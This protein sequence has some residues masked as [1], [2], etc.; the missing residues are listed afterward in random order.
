M[1]WR[2]KCAHAAAATCYACVVVSARVDDDGVAAH[3]SCKL[4][5]RCDVTLQTKKE[6]V[7]VTRLLQ[8]RLEHELFFCAWHDLTRRQLGN[9]CAQYHTTNTV[10]RAQIKATPPP[11]KQAKVQ[12]K[13]G[14]GP[15]SDARQRVGARG[16][17]RQLVGWEILG[18][19]CIGLFCWGARCV[20]R[21]ERGELTE[22]EREVGSTQASPA[23]AIG[24]I[25]Q[26]D[27]P[28]ESRAQSKVKCRA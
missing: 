24:S 12:R 17:A 21:R 11:P 25:G 27:F 9:S 16:V 14:V 1:Q 5:T 18:T 20:Y 22:R 4:W 10:Q 26:G 15:H 7:D 2:K 23:L 8:T 13:K 3:T 19:S 28:S 6:R